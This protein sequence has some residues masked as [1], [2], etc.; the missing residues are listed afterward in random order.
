MLFLVLAAVGVYSMVKPEDTKAAPPTTTSAAPTTAERTTRTRAPDPA[1]LQDRLFG[2]LP[3]GY[4]P[5]VCQ[6]VD[7]PVPG[8]LATVDC[9]PSSMPGGP[10]GSRYSTFPDQGALR[11]NFDE[12]IG[13][14]DGTA[15]YLVIDS[16]GRDNTLSRY[17]HSHADRNAFSDANSAANRFDCSSG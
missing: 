17:A 3:Q 4:D 14:F 9:G 12:A 1:I 10:V 2:M 8:A 15:D 11:A 5:G 7:P 16:P 13:D 6:A